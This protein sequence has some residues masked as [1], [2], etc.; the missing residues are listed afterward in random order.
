MHWTN[1][2]KEKRIQSIAISLIVRETRRLMTFW[3]RIKKFRIKDA[4]F[5]N[6]PP[7]TAYTMILLGMIHF[8]IIASALIDLRTIEQY[9]WGIFKS[10]GLAD[11]YQLPLMAG[12]MI[13]DAFIM[14]YGVYLLKHVEQS[15][16]HKHDLPDK[17]SY[18]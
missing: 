13:F 5:Q 15:D 16:D 11:T 8:M 4:K 7:Q 3:S 17:S 14:I 2:W 10:L 12:L 6:V 18:Q 9:N 1:A